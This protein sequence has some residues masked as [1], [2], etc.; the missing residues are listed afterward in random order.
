MKNLAWMNTIPFVD[1]SSRNSGSVNGVSTSAFKIISAAN[2]TTVAACNEAMNDNS[3]PQQGNKYTESSTDVKAD[4]R[5][6]FIGGLPNCG[7][8]EWRLHICD[9]RNVEFPFTKSPITFLQHLLVTDDVF[10]QYFEKFGKTVDSVVMYD[11]LTKRSRGFG[12]VT[13]E[14]S[15]S[16]YAP[17]LRVSLDLLSTSLILS[18]SFWGAS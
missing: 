6:L 9:I 1:E 13:F 2:E 18:S 4:I 10:F 16:L 8:Y 11:K 14:D 12:F 15:V 7:K 5:K 17:L 3:N